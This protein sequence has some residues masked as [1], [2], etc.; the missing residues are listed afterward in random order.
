MIGLFPS[1]GQARPR[2][3]ESGLSLVELLV[4]MMILGLVLAMVTGLFMSTT[5]TVAFSRSIDEATG[6]ASNASNELSRVIR[7]GTANPKSGSATSDPAFLYAG[8]EKL[9]MLS[10][11]DVD[12]AASIVDRG[13]KPTMVSFE[14]TTTSRQLIESRWAAT[15]SGRFWVLPNPDTTP[16]SSKRNLGGKIMAAGSDAPLFSYYK[17]DGT[18]IVAPATGSIA[19]GSLAAIAMVKITLKVQAESGAPGNLVVVSNTVRL[20]NLAVKTT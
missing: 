14:L 18:E 15:A 2:S 11:V 4:S 1:D 19:A 9:T 3:G 20:P 12:A 7:V 10:L 5:K 13:V 6:T 8:R 17:A 16:V